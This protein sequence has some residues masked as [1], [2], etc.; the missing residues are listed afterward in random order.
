MNQPGVVDTDNG[1]QDLLCCIHALREWL[2]V[3]MQE[4][5][6][7]W[8]IQGKNQDMMLAPISGTVH[9]AQREVVLGQDKPRATLYP[10]LDGFVDLVFLSRV[11][12][13]A[14]DLEGNVFPVV[15][16]MRQPHSKEPTA[17]QLMNN[18]IS[19]LVEEVPDAHGIVEAEQ[20]LQ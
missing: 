20:I 5:Q 19:V 4:G 18:L 14:E 13:R 12:R 3:C 9:P 8:A 1:F 6:K 2:I 17:A 7:A 15:S 11:L 10:L 16:V